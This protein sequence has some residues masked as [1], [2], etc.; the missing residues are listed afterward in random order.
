MKYILAV[1][2]GIDS[3]ALL[4]LVA[5]DD[6]FKKLHFSGASWPEDFIVAHFDHGIRLESRQDLEFV[7]QLCTN[8]GVR[9]LSKSAKLGFNSS[10]ST[11]REQRYKF[12]RSVAA[13]FNNAFIVTAHHQ[14]DLLETIVINI[15]RGTSWRGLA[16]MINSDIIRPLLN[17]SKADIVSYAIDHNLIWRDDLTNFSAKYF[18]NRVRDR[19][20]IMSP[21]KRQNLLYLYDQQRQLRSEIETEIST[22]FDQIAC[23]KGSNLTIPRYFLIM[24]PDETAIEL[25]NRATC[26]RLTR[27]QLNRLLIFTKASKANRH[28]LFSNVKIS[29]S[30]RNLII[31]L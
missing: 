10:E 9:F 25:L 26:G 17:M 2:G 14:D 31:E 7:D 4:D 28:L 23:D 11:A 5:H 1:S 15:L 24:T 8:Y 3:V 13:D 20:T 18:R 21:D 27:P 19:L 12:L 16:P 22:I 30:Q 6:A 29:T